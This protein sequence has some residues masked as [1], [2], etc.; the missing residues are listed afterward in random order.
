[1]ES[2]NIKS[3][4]SKINYKYKDEKLLVRALT[5]SSYANEHKMKK[6]ENNERLEFLGV[7]A[8]LLE[9]ASCA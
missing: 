5:H 7:L 8:F 1:M 6:F 4:Q 2:K 9:F 3:F